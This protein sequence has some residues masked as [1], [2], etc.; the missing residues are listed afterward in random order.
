MKD[1]YRRARPNFVPFFHN[2]T[3]ASEFYFMRMEINGDRIIVK[4]SRNAG[5]VRGARW[6]SKRR[7]NALMWIIVPP[8]NKQKRSLSVEE[9]EE[10]DERSETSKGS[11]PSF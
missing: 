1:V 9:D 4:S 2:Q 7:A 11:A 3:N 10:E 6:I 5:V 8:S